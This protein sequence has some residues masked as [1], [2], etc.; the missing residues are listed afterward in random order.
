VGSG[1]LFSA[2]Q[3]VN[4]DASTTNTIL[5]VADTGNGRIRKVVVCTGAVSTLQSTYSAPAGV[6]L[7][8][9]T[10]VYVT[11]SALNKVF[12]A[13]PAGACDSTWHHVAVSH[14]NAA[15]TLL[16]Y[17]DGALVGTYQ[18]AT[19]SPPAIPTTGNVLR[20]GWNGLA[21][22]SDLF[23]GSISDARI[24]ADDLSASSDL[25]KISQPPL[26]SYPNANAVSPSS[27]ATIYSY[28]CS[29]GWAGPNVSWVRSFTD[30]GWSLGPAGVSVSCSLCPA[31]TFTTST[32]SSACTPCAAGLYGATSAMGSS[33]CTGPCA[34]GFYCPAGSTT[35]NAFACG[36]VGSYCPA[37]SDAPVTVPSGS[38]SGPLATSPTQR[39][40]AIA[41]PPQR[42]CAGGI[43]YPAVDISSTCP[44]GSLTTQ[45]PDTV[46]SVAY[47]PV[48]AAS[49]LGNASA[50]VTW[51][52]VNTTVNDNTACSLAPFPPLLSSSGNRTQL[53][54]G[55]TAVSAS[56]CS[57]G[58]SVIV[59]AARTA[60]N[61]TTDPVYSVGSVPPFLDTCTVRVYPIVSLR[62]P[63]LTFCKGSITVPE[64]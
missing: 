16:N 27:G 46:S 23:S 45:L 37:G 9:L 22:N 61:A 41:C 33:T 8:A 2:P 28:A 36:G 11:D 38:Y 63:S 42:L 18:L 5:Y 58:F 44:T 29:P 25:L 7:D 20:I 47:G 62:S 57:A 1:A 54:I 3:S 64:R 49:T 14:A 51:T 39:S 26:V 21:T 59:K 30:V 13:S 34:A 4:A 31:G 12:I 17:V 52:I 10:N 43:L 56:A 50:G 40:T 35:A 55:A 48:L 19:G 60:A 53:A 6:F 24:Y 32:N 15:I